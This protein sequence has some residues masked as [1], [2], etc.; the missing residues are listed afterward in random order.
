[1]TRGRASA[2]IFLAIAS[3]LAL[4]LPG[5]D[6]QPAVP[7]VPQAV[8]CESDFSAMST[9]G[10]IIVY[11]SN[12]TACHLAIAAAQ[13]VL[14][15]IETDI[16]AFR[17]DSEISA[18][19]SAAGAGAVAISPRTARAI[20][21]AKDYSRLSGGAFNPL[22]GPIM[23]LW[24]T[25]ADEQRL[26]SDDEIRAALSLLDL[27]QIKLAAGD[28]R[29]ICRLERPGMML[30]LGGMAKGWAADEAIAAARQV[31]GV[32]AV[33]V[34][35]GGDGAGWSDPAWSRP[36]SFGIQN[37][38]R[39]ETREIADRLQALNLAVVT[40]GNY[41]RYFEIRGRRYSHIINPRT[42]LPVESDVLS[43]TVT[44][45]DGGRAD[46]LATACMVLGAEG[47]VELLE[48]IEGAEGLI[49]QMVDG[50]TVA[51]RTSGYQGEK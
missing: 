12:D 42:G 30:D 23:Q 50:R 6:D 1:M 33:L 2:L 36:W 47:A 13:Q 32:R 31:K 17:A 27:E 35:I 20:Q 28:G 48:G 38:R 8:R 24:R 49:L 19:N 46:A 25:A 11:A 29:H 22:V 39:P 15:D 37:P 16:S 18:I 44:D 10:Q 7:A 43:A 34:M 41:Y 40:S 51:R 9:D 14:H 26:P 21:A 4:S 3:V 45:A 5:C